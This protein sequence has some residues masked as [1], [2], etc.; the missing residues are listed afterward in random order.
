MW[1]HATTGNPARHRITSEPRSYQFRVQSCLASRSGH[2]AE[3]RKSLDS[4]GHQRQH[5]LIQSESG[6]AI[7]RLTVSDIRFGRS[8]G[9]L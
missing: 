5:T 1:S 7:L 8:S 3:M 4:M 9:R 6:A 2:T